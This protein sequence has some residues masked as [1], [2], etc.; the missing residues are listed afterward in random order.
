[1]LN[2]KGQYAIKTNQIISQSLVAG[3]KN[4]PKEIIDYQSISS[5][6]SLLRK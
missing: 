2:S 6:L 1:M 4:E 3:I 5:C